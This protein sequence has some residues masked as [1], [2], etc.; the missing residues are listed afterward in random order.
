[1]SI[2]ET[3][4]KNNIFDIEPVLQVGILGTLWWHYSFLYINKN[5]EINKY[6][7][8]G[9]LISFSRHNIR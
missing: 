8:S 5:V 4:D 7:N 9:S 6:F 3:R 2:F 1:M